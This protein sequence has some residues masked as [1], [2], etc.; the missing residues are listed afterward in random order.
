MSQVLYFKYWTVEIQNELKIKN[1][2]W[3]L[4][5][6]YTVAFEL[7]ILKRKP[8]SKNRRDTGKVLP[9]KFRIG[10]TTASDGKLL[11]LYSKEMIKYSDY[12]HDLSTTIYEI[13]AIIDDINRTG[14][15][16]IHEPSGF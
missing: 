4:R 10:K 16:Y 15:V 12:E 6:I 5:N 11:S 14:E 7:G 9:S 13:C 3:T 8:T 1:L 2:P